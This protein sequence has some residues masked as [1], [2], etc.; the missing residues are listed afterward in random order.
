MKQPLKAAQ[1]LEAVVRLGKATTENLYTL[2]DIYL[3]ENLMDLACNAYLRSINIDAKQLLARPLQSADMLV[4]RGAFIQAKQILAHI[5]ENWDK[6]MDEA[7]HRKLLKLETRINMADG[8]DIIETA[9]VL[10]EIM[11]LDPING[12]SLMLLGQYYYRQNEQDRA[13]FYYKRAE[14]IE[15]FEA[16][17]K[18]R[19]SQVLVSMGRYSEAVPLLCRAQE[20]KPN[21]DVARYLGQIDSMSKTR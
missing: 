19:H 17:A 20:I 9:K 18:I 7:N 16:N 3:S 12:E 21:D 15:A 14:S 1:N 8:V 13:I 10:E 2:G 6:Q 5:R 11:K 4:Y